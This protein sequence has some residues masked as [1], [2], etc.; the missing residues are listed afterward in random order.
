MNVSA[1]RLICF[2]KAY[3]LPKRAIVAALFVLF[4]ASV[5]APYVVR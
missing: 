1:R 4:F 2:G 5:D 3:F